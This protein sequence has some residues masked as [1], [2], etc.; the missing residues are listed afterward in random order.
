M[1]AESVSSLNISEQELPCQVR[2]WLRTLLVPRRKLRFAT[3]N[4]GSLT[5]RCME[6]ADVLMRRRIQCAFLQETRWKG[7]ES[8]DIGQGY[9][10]V[11]TGSSTGRNGVAVVL[12]E[13]LRKNLLEVDHRCDRLMRVRVQIEGVT[14]NLICAYAPQAGCSAAEKKSFWEQ[15][16][17]LLRAVPTTEG[18]I[19]GGDFNGHVGRSAEIYKGVHGGFG[20]GRRNVEGQKILRTCSSFDLAIVNTFFAKNTQQLITY[21]SGSHS[22]QIDYLLIRRCHIGK[23]TNCKVI[24]GESLTPQHRLLVMDLTDTS[25]RYSNRF[26]SGKPYTC[27]PM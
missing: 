3:W 15:F 4:I 8:Y 24:P 11:Y 16:E 6:L 1:N 25:I 2:A 9:Q 20:Y 27:F 5:R 13:E 18:I 26:P 12:C 14:T 23:V 17:D 22:T 19:V 10:L 7:D 21:K